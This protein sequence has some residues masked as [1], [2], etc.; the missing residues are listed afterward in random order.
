MTRKLFIKNVKT[1]LR[2]QENINQNHIQGNSR[3]YQLDEITNTFLG[4][5]VRLKNQFSKIVNSFSYRT[6]LNT[7]T[8]SHIARVKKSY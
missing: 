2:N 7:C 1:N 5:L 4:K 6:R 8:Q 3:V